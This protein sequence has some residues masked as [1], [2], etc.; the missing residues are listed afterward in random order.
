[1]RKTTS[2]ND[3]KGFIDNF[4][5]EVS[6]LKAYPSSEQNNIVTK[7]VDHCTESELAA[8]NIKHFY[9]FLA[10]EVTRP[11]SDKVIDFIR[12]QFKTKLR[13]ATFI[14]TRHPQSDQGANIAYK[15]K[16]VFETNGHNG[17]SNLSSYNLKDLS[18][19][20]IA[21]RVIKNGNNDAFMFFWR[22]NSKI[23]HDLTFRI[24]NNP[25]VFRINNAGISQIVCHTLIRLYIFQLMITKERIII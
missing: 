24:E 23:K 16:L 2:K 13:G 11:V 9:E 10:E 17:H 18:K 12:Q 7:R 20:Q 14:C 8:N 19:N 1:M 4:Q 21:F 22:Q 15:I 5:L 3:D 6:L 25:H